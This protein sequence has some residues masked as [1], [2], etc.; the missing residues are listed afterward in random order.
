MAEDCVQGTCPGRV[1]GAPAQQS[2]EG[3]SPTNQNNWLGAGQPKTSA[4]PQ[5]AVSV[6]TEWTGENVLRSKID[7]MERIKATKSPKA[8][9]TSYAGMTLWF[10]NCVRVRSWVRSGQ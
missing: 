5:T 8:E 9:R 4:A 6:E 1:L 10:Q 3:R 7:L 2:V